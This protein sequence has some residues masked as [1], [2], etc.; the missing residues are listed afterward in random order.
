MADITS[1]RSNTVISTIS[2]LFFETLTLEKLAVTEITFQDH[3]RSSLTTYD[4][5]LVIHISVFHRF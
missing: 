3:S 5:M 4:F 2:A 1:D